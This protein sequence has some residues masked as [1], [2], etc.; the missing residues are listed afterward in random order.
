MHAVIWF[1]TS[2]LDV[3]NEPENPINP[4]MGA[5]LLTWIQGKEIGKVSVPDPDYEDWG[6]YANIDFNGCSYMLGA[7]TEEADEYG[8][9]QF[10]FQVKKHRTLKDKILQR[11]KSTGDTDP[12]YQYF[13][14]LLKSEPSFVEFE[15][16][17]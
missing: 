15:Y 10:C 8:Q 12:C 9:Y 11:K 13:K 2:S 17:P 6:W 7:S 5:S 3:E 4:I 16:E 14:Q 1:K